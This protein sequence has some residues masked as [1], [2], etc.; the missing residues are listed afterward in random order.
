MWRAARRG[1]AEPAPAVATPSAMESGISVIATL[2]EAP[3]RTV[4][5]A[6]LVRS[7]PLSLPLRAMFEDRRFGRA[8][9]SIA[10]DID[11]IADQLP[12][13]SCPSGD[14]PFLASD[15]SLDDLSLSTDGL[16]QH[17]KRLLAPLVDR[18]LDR[19]Q[20]LVVGAGPAGLMA[21][22][23]LRL[24]DHRVVVCEQ[25]E[26]YARNRYIGVYKEVTHLMA[27]LGMPE[28]MTYDFS[29]Y[30]GK[31]GIMLADI[32]TFLHG[33]AL[34]LG[35]VIY[36]GAVARSLSA[37]ELREGV[38]ELQR[39]A[40]APSHRPSAIGMT[41]WQFDTV[42][43]VR[44]G[45]S[46]RFD[47]V[48]EASGGRSGLREVLV[49]SGNVV[50]LREVGLDAARR[51]PTLD[52]FFDD[53]ED[54][55][56]EYVES[57]YGCPP[58]T[59]PAFARALLEGTERVIPDSVPCFVSNIDASVLKRP[60]QQ[61]AVSLGLASRIGD[62]DLA[63]PHDWVV[64]ECRLS[65]QSLARYHIEGPLPQDFEFGGRRVPTRQVLDGLNPVGLLLRIL[66]A[67]GLP[68]DAV[69]RRQLVEF[70]ETES[71]YG[72]VSDI[73]SMWVGQFRGLR[74]GQSRPIWRGTVPGSDAIEYGIVGEALQN[75]W[76][77]FGVGVDDAVTGASYFAAGFDL[78]PEA[79][80]EAA[81]RLERIATA[82]SVQILYHLFSVARD[83]DQGVV[84]HVLT[85]YYMDQRR[86]EDVADTRLRELAGVAQE[87]RSVEDDLRQGMAPDGLLAVALDQARQASARRILA[88]LE[89]F[90][91]PR[92][93]L[94]RAHYAAA[95]NLPDWRAR[96]MALL[97][98]LLSPEHRTLLPLFEAPRAPTGR[99]DD[100]PG[101]ERLHELALG[102]YGWATPW[103]RACA[104]QALDAAAPAAR[105]V[106]DRL[107]ADPDL[108]VAETAAAL[109]ARS[110]GV[111][112]AARYTT[113]DKVL[114]LRDVRLFAAV[115]LEVL[116]RVA[117]RLT[118]RRV[119]RD[120][121]IIRG[122][123][124]GDSLYVIATGSVRVHDGERV[125]QVLRAPRVFGELALLDAEPRSASV[126]AL[127]PSCLLRL[128]QGDFYTLLGEWP[129]M[130]RA[131]NQ[132][133][134][135][136]VRRANDALRPAAGGAQAVG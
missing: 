127:E 76:Y 129:D 60:M 33:I 54:H 17:R 78:V 119:M 134:C 16:L 131:V 109:C 34:K 20:V 79:R 53:P 89:S 30:R 80:V 42:T 88:L 130:T 74:V 55:C 39:A 123:E 121:T 32:Q 115:P 70:Y 9:D 94:A 3:H 91:Y 25:R 8:F 110:S 35:A 45:A 85:E 31:R 105:D 122:G 125:L 71:S 86:D 114:V 29:Q 49:G 113:L 18:G 83:A 95:H 96:T 99:T 72:D 97:E 37:G 82:R 135:D 77:R 90:P 22:I 10:L 73:V 2:A 106:L 132:A 65:D 12:G 84:G 23:Q 40:A 66:Y 136:M 6:A 19:R 50:S 103:L 126:S 44:S 81:R 100:G 13:L 112:A 93:A 101:R 107:Q 56:A 7:S 117:D 47:A 69:D 108:L 28:R 41:R 1:T 4:H 5:S 27:A 98:P 124:L 128:T 116:A 92:D 51:D 14:V 118:E 15:R 133:L 21:A 59:R 120:E 75:A 43:Q 104:M 57:G 67:M 48:L 111:Q 36:T 64:L 24:R 46:V 52:S 102:R 58:G 68:F 63:I 26:V 38:V 61:T 62:R 87:M 11:A